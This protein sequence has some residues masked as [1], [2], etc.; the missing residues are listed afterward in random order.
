MMHK[1]NKSSAMNMLVQQKI[2]MEGKPSSESKQY[3]A[4]SLLAISFKLQAP[5]NIWQI[6]GK[7]ASSSHKTSN[8]INNSK[9]DCSTKSCLFSILD[10]ISIVDT[11]TCETA[12]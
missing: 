5:N 3:N 12:S 9:Q 10:L 11:R 6:G 4:V 7:A 2:E 1:L 8:F